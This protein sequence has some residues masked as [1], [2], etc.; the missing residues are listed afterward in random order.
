MAERLQRA[1][2]A[3]S[4]RAGAKRAD[5]RVVLGTVVV[6][7][8]ALGVGLFS[9]RQ[10]IRSLLTGSNFVGGNAEV[11]GLHL[12]S[13]FHATVFASGLNAPRFLAFGPDGGLYVA[14]RGANSIVALPDANHS[15]ATSG[16]LVVVSGLND[17]TSVAFAGGMLYVGERTQVSRFPL[18]ANS[19]VGAKQVIVQGLPASGQHTTRTV[20]IGADGKLYVAVGS[21]CN[22]CDESDPHRASVW[23]YPANGGTGQRYAQ[24]L[25]NAVGLAVN[26]WNQQI[27]ATNNGRDLLGDNTP[28]ETIYALRD[29]ANYGWPRCHA[30]TII[31]P[32]MGHA[33]DCN[34]VVAPLV[35]MQAHS[36]PLGL[37][38]YNGT[39][40]PTQYRG[41]FVAFHGSW[42]RSAPT[43]YK[44]IFLPL[45]A[46]GNI[47]GPPQDFA[48]GWLHAD[49]TASGRPVGVAV[50]PDGALYVSDDK[51]GLVY[52]ITY[53]S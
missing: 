47:A 2:G 51:A 21:S 28:P 31:D 23:V 18:L 52:R 39:V 48:T 44:V 42:N 33:G 30:G 17:P 4:Q 35:A 27:W 36:A 32:D 24:G 8:V 50:G 13:G 14:E 5:R 53:T 26:P 29:G 12:P 11:T 9:Q 19:A 20:L 45:D 46:K 10:L 6:L 15:G 38:F 41:L 1:R 43:G 22:V 40:F 7:L 3:S 49:G 16:K 25:R 37:A 34:G